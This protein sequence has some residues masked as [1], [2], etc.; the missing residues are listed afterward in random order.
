MAMDQRLLALFGELEKSGVARDV[1]HF[2]QT[3]TGR[4]PIRVGT[5]M[6]KETAYLPDSKRSEQK[7]DSEKAEDLEAEAGHGF[8]EKMASAKERREQAIGAAAKARPWIK[9]GIKGAIPAAVA[10][11]FLIP[12]TKEPWIGRKSKIVAGVT[13]A[14]AGLGLADKALRDWAEK[15]KRKRVAREIL[16]TSEAEYEVPR[17][18]L[19]IRK[20]ASLAG[21]LR[22]NGLGGVKRP[23]FPTEDSKRFASTLIDRSKKPG[24]FTGYA[25]P[26]NLL[27]PG[28][29]LSSVAT[30]PRNG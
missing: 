7:Q 12:A 4:R 14:G 30:M 22:M 2:M 28:P 29:A 27:K 20:V 11:N 13:A 18:Q 15:N 24:E 10:A 9:S 16:K 1:S 6:K 19:L 26:K 21:D 23:P 3:R 5:L 17:H 8:A 25:K